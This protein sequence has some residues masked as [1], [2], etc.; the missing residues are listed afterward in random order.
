LSQTF[1]WIFDRGL[2][3]RPGR[4]FSDRLP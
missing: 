4:L 3:R 1:H 2:H